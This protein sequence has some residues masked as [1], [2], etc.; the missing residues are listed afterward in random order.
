MAPETNL[1]FHVYGLGCLLL[2]CPRSSLP[3]YSWD[4]SGQAAV[5]P[6]TLSELVSFVPLSSGINVPHCPCR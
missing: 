4:T 6:I 3:C 5:L 2:G 1:N